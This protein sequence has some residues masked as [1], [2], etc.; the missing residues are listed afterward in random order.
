[1]SV[2][3]ATDIGGT[4]TDLVLV[5]E[6]T[7]ELRIAKASTTP[8]QLAQGVLDALAKGEVDLAD[9]RELVHGTTVVINALTERRGARTAL[10]TTRGFRDVL[11]LTRGNRPDMYNLLSR[12][13]EPF[14]PRRH[15]FEVRER[16]D[17][18]GSV[19][20]PLALADLDPIVEACQRDGI[21][22]V[23]VCF[24]HAYAHPEHERACAEE[25]RRR[26]PG[27]AV[28]ASSEITREWRE[29][30]RTST[31]VLNAFVQ[32]TVDRYLESLEARLGD[33]GLAGPV[34]IM[35]SNAGT[36]SPTAA[37][38]RPIA[39]VESGPAGGIVGAARLGERIGEPDILYL[40]IGGTTA[41][42]SLIQGG[43]PSTTTEYRI[44]W[45]PDHAGYPVMVPVVDIVE[46]GAG[47]G[48]IAWIDAGGA[49]K[50]GPRSAGAVPGPACYGQG[51]VDPTVT[52]AKLAA[53]VLDPGYFLGG[54]LEVDRG[55]SI[56]A[57][58]RLGRELGLDAPEVANGIIRL[59][60]ANMISA[61]KLVSVRRG[62]DPR[63]FVLVAAGGG[64]P[65][66]AA[67]LAQELQV[68][69]L[70]VPP[71]SGV[72][73]AWG[74]CTTDPRV[75]VVQTR[76]LRVDASSD[77]EVT[78]LFAALEQEAAAQFRSD[79]LADGELVC[80]RSVHMR[81]RGQEHTVAVAAPAGAVSLAA[82]EAGFHAEHR[83]AYTF[84]LLDTPVELVTFQVAASLRRDR[85]EAAPPRTG[86]GT[87]SPK[88]RRPVDFDVDGVHDTPVY[89]RDDLPLGFA[90]AGPLVI[91]ESTT[92]T[93]VHPGQELHVDAFG[94][95]VIELAP[96]R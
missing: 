89:A 23:A 22:A 43:N 76:I 6:A 15:R 75:D 94:N 28:S 74:M 5:D 14:V 62:H 78:A 64:G 61:L 90:A 47:G 50:V 31:T 88:G 59:V 16:V 39:L 70:V 56:A 54:Q 91:E 65:M 52:D 20:V 30:E 69:R 46:I 63:D 40:D 8:G 35:Q 17:R 95:L 85:V 2:R 73:S 10:V 80:R 55:L 77:E 19:L 21:E 51:G 3:V 13:P 9:T 45:R 29:Y 1:M 81:Y 48:S 83:R 36:A 7:G 37:R 96:A 41:K 27:V 4:F 60:N 72:F 11:E 79:G 68:R 25:L 42:C 38:A 84:D 24:L 93:L 26:L 92:T 58:E 33:G 49:I 87:P 71:Y 12:K 82:L 86:A 53:G 66:H 67:A 32:P 18:H 34:Q 57:L 44:D